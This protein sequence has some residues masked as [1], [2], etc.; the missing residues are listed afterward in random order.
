[1][2]L[3]IIGAE[4]SGDGRLLVDAVAMVVE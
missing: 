2:V 4:L 1:L 3:E